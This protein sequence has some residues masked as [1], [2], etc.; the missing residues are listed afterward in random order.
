MLKR[1]KSVCVTVYRPSRK[2]RRTRNWLLRYRNP[3]TGMYTEK[4]S[5]T[6]NKQ[7]ALRLA[8][9]LRDH[10]ARKQDPLNVPR[11]QDRPVVR[12]E[13]ICQSVAKRLKSPRAHNKFSR[14]TK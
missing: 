1:P 12:A 7:A 6:S 2:G 9:Q 11:G 4:S 10:L 3:Q 8:S 5:G 13:A 14:G